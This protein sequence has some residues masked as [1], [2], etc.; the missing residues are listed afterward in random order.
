MK[1]VASRYGGSFSRKKLTKPSTTVAGILIKEVV[2][3]A[4]E[5]EILCGELL[6]DPAIALES[7][8]VRAA[9]KQGDP[10]KVREALLENS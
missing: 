9:L 2:V 6:I 10:E 8:A 4:I 1:S 7:E 5:F 3:T